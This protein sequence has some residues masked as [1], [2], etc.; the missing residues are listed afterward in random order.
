MSYIREG[1]YKERPKVDAHRQLNQDTNRDVHVKRDNCSGIKLY[2]YAIRSFSGQNVFQR[3]KP[4][5][6]QYLQPEK[7]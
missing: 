1:G 6:N 5:I 2:W 7:T 3:W 4:G